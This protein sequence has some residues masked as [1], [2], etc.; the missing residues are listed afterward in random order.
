MQTHDL[1]PYLTTAALIV[2]TIILALV[3]F[4]IKSQLEAVRAEIQLGTMAA[5]A[6][7][8]A[9]RGEFKLGMAAAET[10]FFG[11]VNGKYV[12]KDILDLRLQNIMCRDCA[13]KLGSV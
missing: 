9:V 10:R 6:K 13:V 1:A 8:E 12:R 5:E 2:A 4:S 7:L 3:G 11:L